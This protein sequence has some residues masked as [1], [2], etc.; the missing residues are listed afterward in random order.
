MRK[1]SFHGGHASLSPTSL[2]MWHAAI[3]LVALALLPLAC[4]LS[5]SG[6]SATIPPGNN[7]RVSAPVVARAEARF[8]LGDGAAI[9]IPASSLESD[10]TAV[11]E[12]SPS[13]ASSLP[14]LGEDVLPIGE[15]YEFSFQG[16]QPI[17]PVQVIL[18]FDAASIPTDRQPGFPT[19]AFPDGDTW[20]FVPVPDLGGYVAVTTQSIGDPI[21]AWHIVDVDGRV[22]LSYKTREPL[23]VCDPEISLSV[24]PEEPFTGMPLQI[25]GRVNPVN[26][27]W[28]QVI[29]D[30]TAA[31]NLDVTLSFNHLEPGSGHAVTVQTDQY[32]RFQF[33]LDPESFEEF[34]LRDV[35]WV[36]AEARCDPWFG[37][38]N[39][40]SIGLAVFFLHPT[41]EP[42][43]GGGALTPTAAL[44]S[45]P[46]APADV[47]RAPASAPA[48]SPLVE[49]P[50]VVGLPL[51]DA[52]DIIEDSGFLTTWTDGPSTYPLGYIFD[53]APD[54]GQRRDPRFTTVVLSRSTQLLPNPSPEPDSAPGPT[55]EPA[56]DV[57]EEVSLGATTTAGTVYKLSGPIGSLSCAEASSV[58][59]EETGMT[60]NGRG[61]TVLHQPWIFGAY[62]AA[63]YSDEL[64]EI[65]VGLL[66]CSDAGLTPEEEANCGSHT[67][68]MTAT[69]G[70][71]CTIMEI[72]DDIRQTTIGV[73]TQG[74][75][76]GSRLFPRLAPNTYEHVRTDTREGS[77]IVRHV[78]TVTLTASGFDSA[79]AYGDEAEL[80]DCYV[81]SYR[82][83]E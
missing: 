37:R 39:V 50:S 43:Q 27:S 17:G 2:P 7:E 33:T 82:L 54:A 29:F 52:V 26:P 48:T 15:Y 58:G 10:T 44:T 72:A 11:I 79:Y 38:V 65:C 19:V 46:T 78:T 13:K 71:N 25:I 75:F 9:V 28:F 21:I 35:N 32:G 18:P 59:W 5:G 14:P 45:V 42:Q 66:S 68:Q 4:S 73:S 81:L 56:I 41:G 20:S 31:S 16:P 8:E 12:R 77:N 62:R 74:L 80:Y 51:H 63:V 53:Q 67:Y 47:T 69:I 40:Q 1:P 61:V 55:P 6:P 34:A 76:F 64:T 70:P 60:Y 30:Q 36:E 3:P 24:L 49:I 83:R 22:D 23:T 57:Y